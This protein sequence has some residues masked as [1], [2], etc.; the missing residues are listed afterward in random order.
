VLKIGRTI[1]YNF[2]IASLWIVHNPGAQTGA[3]R[4]QKAEDGGEASANQLLH[5]LHLLLLG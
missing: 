2:N 3:S 5:S 1:K 4:H